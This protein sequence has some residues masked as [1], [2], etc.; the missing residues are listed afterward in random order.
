LIFACCAALSQSDTASLV[1]PAPPERVR[2]KFIQSITSIQSFKHEGG[3]FS[4]MLSFF[5][6]DNSSSQWLVQPVGIAVSPKDELYIA[7][8]GANGIHV[9]N[10]EK[11]EYDFLAQ[12]K[13]E[14]FISPVGIA[15]A[16]DGTIYIA[17]SQRGDITVLDDDRDAISQIKDHLV[18][19]TGL[20]IHGDTLFVVDASQHKVL[21]YDLAGGYLSEIGQRGSEGGNFNFPIQIAGKKSLY[22]VDALNYRVQHFG[23]GG[24]YV[25][26]FGRQ[27]NTEGTFAS[28]K[29]IA[30]DSDDNIYVTDALMD[31]FQIFNSEGQLLLV[32]GQHGMRDGQ[33]LSPGGICIDAND[34][35]YVADMLN[36]R[37]EVFK[38][39][40]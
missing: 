37:I 9:I 6:G 36:K 34:K 27:G 12:T 40:K 35:I 26:S 4:K 14:S 21:L 17:D 20:C 19:P 32:V 18:R 3:F 31:N 39:L 28:P 23:S 2:I 16:P 5:F 29:A 33:F 25:S 8:P 24:K 11:K 13:F 15:F 10:Q 30:L 22:V 1:W 38:Y 7:D